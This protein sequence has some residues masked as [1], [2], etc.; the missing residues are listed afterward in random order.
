MG[1]PYMGEPCSKLAALRCFWVCVQ[2]QGYLAQRLHER[3]V[4][5]SYTPEPSALEYESNGGL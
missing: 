1:V 5:A 3:L 2:R 4:A